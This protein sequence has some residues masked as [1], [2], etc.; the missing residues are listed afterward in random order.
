MHLRLPPRGSPQDLALH[1]FSS[2]RAAVQ[3]FCNRLYSDL[4]GN[5][6]YLKGN[7]KIFFA[8]AAGSE[9][10]SEEAKATRVSVCDGPGQSDGDRDHHCEYDRRA[11]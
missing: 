11:V 8:P 9:H 2:V 10:N 4:N 3:I 6:L 7:A 5:L 1:S